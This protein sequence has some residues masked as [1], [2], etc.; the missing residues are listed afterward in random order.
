MQDP[1]RTEGDY[2]PISRPPVFGGGTSSI[3]IAII[4]SIVVAWAMIG[5]IGVTKTAYHSDITRLEN[6]LVAMRSTDTNIS[7]KLD[8]VERTLGVVSDN[9]VS[10]S[11]LSTTLGS[12][13]L[14]SEL[15]GYAKSSD[16]ESYAPLTTLD[17]YYTKNATNNITLN[18][19][20]Q[21]NNLTDEV[22]ELT[23]RVDNLTVQINYLYNILNITNLTAV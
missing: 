6:D 23:D 5:L 3:I 19:T 1:N 22:E 9:Y 2:E 17:S 10:T 20:N 15:S 18:L 7:G 11:T 8:S 12:Y 16:L 14:K 21:I 13:A 4:I